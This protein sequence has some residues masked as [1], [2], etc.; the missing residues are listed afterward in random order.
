MTKINKILYLLLLG[1]LLVPQAQ[2]EWVDISTSV[3]ISQTRQAMDRVNR[4]LFSYVTVT[5]TSGEALVDPVRLV[6]TNPNVPVLNEEGVTDTGESYLQIAEG[7][8][9]GASTKVRVDFQLQRTQLS[10]A[11]TIETDTQGVETPCSVNS[12]FCNQNPYTTL[13]I[14][15]AEQYSGDL[16]LRLDLAIVQVRDT[17]GVTSDPFIDNI[18][19][20]VSI[21]NWQQILNNGMPLLD[22]IQILQADISDGYLDT[23][24]EPKIFHQ[25]SE[26][27]VLLVDESDYEID[28]SLPTYV[29]QLDEDLPIEFISLPEGTVVTRQL[30]SMHTEEGGSS[31]TSK[32]YLSD[33]AYIEIQDFSAITGNADDTIQRTIYQG[34]NVGQWKDKLNVETTV[35]IRTFLSEPILIF[36]PNA[37][38]ERVAEILIRQDEFVQAVQEY[39]KIITQSVEKNDELF[40]EL[41]MTLGETGNAQL[42]TTQIN[43]SSAVLTA[44]IRNIAQPQALVRTPKSIVS[45]NT[46]P[47]KVFSG[48]SLSYEMASNKLSAHSRSSLW[49]G[50]QSEQNFADAGLGAWS[51]TSMLSP[52]VGFVT[53]DDIIF[54]SNCPGGAVCSS[55][56][57][58]AIDN[59]LNNGNAVNTVL[60]RNNPNSWVDVPQVMNTLSVAQVLLETIGAS[61]R[62][63][64]HI[65]PNKVSITIQ[66]MVQRVAN[67]KEEYKDLAKT[68]IAALDVSLIL[69]E[70]IC[71]EHDSDC[72]TNLQNIQKLTAEMGALFG[73]FDAGATPDNISEEQYLRKAKEVKRLFY[74]A[75]TGKKFISDSLSLLQP[76]LLAELVIRP[77]SKASG[78]EMKGAEAYIL[79]RSLFTKNDTKKGVKAKQKF[80]QIWSKAVQKGFKPKKLLISISAFDSTVKQML[81]FNNLIN[82]L[83]KISGKEL[84]LEITRTAAEKANVIA[85]DVLL[86]AV[87][88]LTPA[89]YL[90]IIIASNKL[91]SMAYDF[92]TDPT[93]VQ[94][95]MRK[96]ATGLDIEHSIPDLKAIR[97]LKVSDSDNKLINKTIPGGHRYGKTFWNLDQEDYIALGASNTD[98][99]FLVMSGFQGSIENQSAFLKKDK[100][101]V[102]ALMD[103]GKIKMMWHVKK[104]AT[105]AE[106]KTIRLKERGENNA[107]NNNF[108]DNK[109]LENTF[110]WFNN[111]IINADSD[112]PVQQS[113]LNAG[114]STIGKYEVLDFTEFYNQEVG[115]F[116]LSHITP[117]VY[118]DYTHISF[119]TTKEEALFANTL[120]MY[121]LPDFTSRQERVQAD[122]KIYKSSDG[123]SDELQLKFRA[124]SDWKAVAENRLWMVLKYPLNGKWHITAPEEIANLPVLGMPTK[125]FLLPEG[126]DLNTASVYLYNDIVN[127]YI[128]H[129]G[130]SISNILNS[131]VSY[132]GKHNESPLILLQTSKMKVTTESLLAEIDSDNDGINDTWD[133]F[134]EDSQYQFDSD[135]DGMPDRWEEA[136]GLN[137]FD[138]SDASVDSDG[139]GVSN[140]DEFINGSEPN[141]I[142]PPQNLNAVSREGAV[143]LTWDLVAN[144]ARYNLYYSTDPDFPQ[145]GTTHE[146]RV[147]SPYTVS[148]LVNG[149]IYYFALTAEDIGGGESLYS[150]MV[151]ATPNVTAPPETPDHLTNMFDTSEFLLGQ[152]SSGAE[153]ADIDTPSGRGVK[154]TQGQESRIQFSLG[155]QMPIEGTLEMR[156]KVSSGFDYTNYNLS[157]DND[158]ALIFTTDVQHGDV[159]YPG[160]TW[161]YVR[162]NGTLSLT[163]AT[164]KYGSQPAQS[165]VAEST[166]FTFDEWHTVSISYGGEGQYLVLDGNVVASNENNT[167][168]LGAG[169]THSRSIDTP[170][171]GESVPGFWRENQYEGGFEGYLDGIRVSPNQRDFKLNNYIGWSNSDDNENSEI[172][173]DGLVAYYPFD[174]DAIN[175]YGS[176]NNGQP[177]NSVYFDDGLLGQAAI[178]GGVDNP[179]YI[180]IP[181]SAAL[182]FSQGAT[183][184]AWF[185]VDDLVRMD[186]YGRRSTSHGGGTIFAKSHDR[187]G[188]AFSAHISNQG[189]GSAGIGVHQTS[190]WNQVGSYPEASWVEGK[191]IGDWTH[192]T[193]TLSSTTGTRIYLDGEISYGSTGPVP[194]G[195]MNN[196]DL[197]I[198]KFSDFWYPFIGAIDEVRIYNRALSE[199]E[200]QALYI[201]LD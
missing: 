68:T 151:S 5:N 55:F 67:F 137:A 102:E 175:H 58:E 190:R 34:F 36:L 150:K 80:L 167:Q 14:S 105:A 28:K 18:S 191:E 70:L 10:F 149:E 73:S 8:E 116:P 177:S 122:A 132:I 162:R 136:Y 39:E 198:G 81:S 185:R 82:K 6:I 22:W 165:I 187:R 148:D 56:D 46:A 65:K 152:G 54:K 96:G 95:S 180:Y 93:M 193:F 141:D 192:V 47:Y 72:S 38:K 57:L 16:S 123:K 2:A 179:G 195:G 131:T 27:P 168:V 63:L 104:F 31:V 200:V 49:Y 52:K 88:N 145:I 121:V 50:I 113:V 153:F 76:I 125:T 33:I 19:G 127:A 94:L 174:G 157:T 111:V 85:V 197:F 41:I 29:D 181:N 12:V 99:H 42:E 32:D 30:Y 84:I 199:S 21:A 194:F 134:P 61:S 66:E 166:D 172:P 112:N 17:L 186:G 101:Q 170:T 1:V 130:K 163:M 43:T 107:F 26:R 173:V 100:S 97:Y 158:H 115:D 40:N 129:S 108:I 171:I 160:S 75:I 13:L 15:L 196:E 106:K 143:E 51:T 3:E 147:Q 62:M 189:V 176:A 114:E 79:S 182:Q 92:I 60:F 91:G 20:E 98:N 135:E 159:T 117:G 44:K 103:T 59:S 77:V 128:K 86:T 4:V 118:S 126:I 183:Y 71:E 119:K 139:D 201:L 109:P 69:L 64:E 169:G 78:V 161:L 53:K 9:Q 25:A 48:M 144:A 156:I 140:F 23:P 133:A 35:L 45:K 89:K 24:F 83:S 11:V 87:K 164:T 74:Y 138:A 110:F 154:F 184:S 120:N 124:S 7:M 155:D 142:F 146:F 37:E 188:A 178:F 90:D